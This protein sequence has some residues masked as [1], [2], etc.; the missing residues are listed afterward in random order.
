MR[1]GILPEIS[2]KKIY[3]SKPPILKDYIT[4]LS[5]SKKKLNM[6]FDQLL[7][8]IDIDDTIDNRIYREMLTEYGRIEHL[9]RCSRKRLEPF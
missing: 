9:E 4:E 5:E 7:T 1:Y 8:D 2:E 3:F 6:F